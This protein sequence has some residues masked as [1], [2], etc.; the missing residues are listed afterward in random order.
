MEQQ[1]QL[2]IF[3]N[4]QFGQVRIIQINNQPWWVLSDV[5]KILDLSNPTAVAN[6]LDDD[7]KQKIDPKSNLG[8]RSNTPITIISES[9]LYAVILRSDKPNAK[10]F[11]RWTTQDVLPS[12]RKHGGYITNSALDQL[13]NNP[14]AAQNFLKSLIE[15]RDKTNALKERL[16]VIQPK[17]DYFDNV[18][19]CN[20]AIPITIIAKTYGYSAMAFNRILHALKIQFPMLMNVKKVWV[21]YAHYQDKGYTV[22]K[23]FHKSDNTSIIHTYFTQKGRCFLYDKLKEHGFLPLNERQKQ[24]QKLPQ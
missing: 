23:T 15:E 20:N 13:I 11:R 18:L 14:Q 5:C 7:E 1:S 2:Q 17:V 16:G 19:N 10:A 4:E 3:E 9:G 12:I 21:L 8:S 6:R 24:Q 22:T